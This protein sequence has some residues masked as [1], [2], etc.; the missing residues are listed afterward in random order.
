MI[1]YFSNINAFLA[2]Q[3][4]LN[5]HVNETL[6]TQINSMQ[7]LDKFAKYENVTKDNDMI[8]LTN[9]NHDK[10]SIIKFKEEIDTKDFSV[11]LDLDHLVLKDSDISGIYAW[12]TEKPISQ[13]T[14]KNGPSK[15]KGFMGG[16][17]FAHHKARFVFSYNMG[18][19]DKENEHYTVMYDKIDESKLENV[20]EIKL[21]IIHTSNNIKFELY[22]NYDRLLSDTFKI[23]D[24]ELVQ[25][26]KEKAYF[27]ITTFY[28]NPK[29]F[30]L[31]ELKNIEVFKRDE[32]EGYNNMD[33]H[34]EYNTHE[35]SES[36]KTVID[37][38]ADIA[39][40]ISY[41]SAAMGTVGETPMQKMVMSFKDE[42]KEL[43][44]KADEIINGEG[45]NLVSEKDDDTAAKLQE[46]DNTMLEIYNALKKMKKEVDHL[47]G[48]H[49]DHHSYVKKGIILFGI[50]FTVATIYKLVQHKNAT[51]YKTLKSLN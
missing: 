36:Q 4:A 44:K 39:H 8:L 11:V 20:H 42:M 48:K 24:P 27:G 38:T 37:A 41:L 34:A 51:R 22:D 16:L 5:A 32:K 9:N 35:H 28:E 19:D 14:L 50:F 25:M 45:M 23:N 29:D 30:N 2:E 10:G 49:A 21:K 17:E 12:F 7:T 47:Q 46:F 40:F 15:F 31:L 6:L 43:Y 18:T 13:G 3:P 1:S 26:E 33:L